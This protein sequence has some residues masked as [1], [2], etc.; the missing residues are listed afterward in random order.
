M[1]LLKLLSSGHV[2]FLDTIN[3]YGLNSEIL[4][5]NIIYLRCCHAVMYAELYIFAY[6]NKVKRHHLSIHLYKTHS[7]IEIVLGNIYI[8]YFF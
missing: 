6:R 4:Y 8:N 1:V 2:M 7:F 5:L 3:T